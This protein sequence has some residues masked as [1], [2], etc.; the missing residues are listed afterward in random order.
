MK[1]FLL[2]FALCFAVLW[3][4][5]AP[6]DLQQAKKIAEKF[7]TSQK[8][9]KSIVKLDLCYVGNGASK[10]SGDASFY[11]FTSRESNSFVITSADDRIAPIL[12]YSTEGE[13]SIDNMPENLRSWLS[14]YETNIPVM[15]KKGQVA[16]SAKGSKGVAPLLCDIAWNQDEP[17]N[18]L[19]PRTTEGKATATG[20]VATAMAQIMR[21]HKWPASATGEVSYTTGSLG[22]NISQNLGDKP[23]DW[24]NMLAIYPDVCTDAQ[25]VAVAQ[26]MYYAGVS[27]HMDYDLSS[28][29][30]SRVVPAALVNNFGYST[31][32]AFYYRD[33]F[34]YADWAQ[35]IKTELDAQR[36]IYYTGTS[37]EGGHAFV[38]DGYDDNG[39]FHIN[40]GWGGMSNGYF[41]LLE[42]NPDAQGIG[43]GGGGG[44][45]NGQSVII[46]I[47]PPQEGDI[48]GK[49]YFGFDFIGTD[50]DQAAV[51]DN[52][53]ITIDYL[54]NYGG[55][56]FN[57]SLGLALYSTTGDLIKI[58]TQEDGIQLAS[59]YGWKSQ[60][61]TTT[62][63]N[64][65]EGGYH[66]K[67]VSKQQGATSWDI[68]KGWN[69]TPGYILA[70]VIGTQVVFHDF[71]HPVLALD[72]S[73]TI[74][75]IYA[76]KPTTLSMVVKNN[77]STEFS[78]NVGIGVTKIGGAEKIIAYSRVVIPAGAS[79]AIS[80][81]VDSVSGKAEDVTLRFLYDI[82]NGF[83]AT[84]TLSGELAIRQVT[85]LPS[86]LVQGN[87]P[88]VESFTIDKSTFAVGE[89]FTLN[90]SLK[91]N[92]ISNHFKS[93]LIF[94]V[95]SAEGGGSVGYVGYNSDFIIAPGATANLT[96]P[97]SLYLTPG[98]Y[99]FAI[100]YNEGSGW[101]QLSSGL[102]FTL[103]KHPN[104]LLDETE[105]LSTVSIY[106]NPVVDMFSIGGLSSNTNTI[107]LVSI[108]GQV[109]LNQLVNS[110]APISIAH[111]AKGV[112]I[113]T[114][115]D[116]NGNVV[117]RMK[118]V[119]L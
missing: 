6:I 104:S 5:G 2:V 81:A 10:S 60:S 116:V 26:L 96:I 35:M 39:L 19:T 105:E 25:R 1:R 33:Y 106:P 91:S 23:F 109:V 77:G 86:T 79:Q 101:T 27:V 47:K 36:P 30:Y 112:Y 42:M 73:L 49:V 113:A 119:K 82:N 107:Q 80:L 9:A 90:A 61:F 111:L 8:G 75:P 37:P 20:C 63:A 56:E 52:V 65:E 11:V 108:Q 94:F 66:V 16:S 46:G 57:G 68:C 50:V 102:P 89:T 55:F 98:N 85:V 117:K 69:A 43:A 12:A 24:N 95:F 54:Y 76:S 93:S 83:S 4:F 28:G 29:A 74:D 31:S 97:G 72:A 87:K 45:I 100:F 118:I 48:P 32:L 59:H 22:F 53:D 114:I 71:S 41:S 103:T 40:W 64:V 51:T 44:Y 15:L 17:Y 21:Y 38:C 115:T 58:L 13:F 88:S 7:I 78:S 18:N 62:F 92:N 70:E 110:N 67:L 14:F 3:G 34:K 99:L 84:D